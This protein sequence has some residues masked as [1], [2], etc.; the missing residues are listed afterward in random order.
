MSFCLFHPGCNGWVSLNNTVETR[1]QNSA[2]RLAKGL[3]LLRSCGIMD[4]ALYVTALT[5]VLLFGF[6]GNLLVIVTIARNATFHR[7]PFFFLLNLSISD[8][9][10]CLFCVPFVI[11]SVVQDVGW[12]HGDVSCTVIAF[13]N[14]FFVFN[15]FITILVIAIDRYVSVAYP[16]IHKRW[17]LQGP[18]SLVLVAIG[19]FLSGLVSLPPVFGDRSYTFVEEENQCTFQHTSY[20]HNDTFGFL[21]VLTAVQFGSFFIYCR[22]FIFLRHHRRMKPLEN[23]PSMSSNW[24]FAGPRLQNMFPMAWNGLPLHPIPTITQN[25]SSASGQIDRIRH[26]KNEHLTRLFFAVALCVYLLWSLYCIQSLVLIFSDTVIP[27]GFRRITT[28]ATFLQVCVSPVTFTFHF[29]KIVINNI[30]VYRRRRKLCRQES[31]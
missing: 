8:L 3:N 23:P 13:T 7:A 30:K 25:L 27:K 6:L 20:K 12:V 5:C 11:A 4:S 10:R 17:L 19:W 21:L 31:H 9:C 24:T 1:H 16:Y 14:F 26:R 15:S 22:I 29:R 28:L 18:T 2:T